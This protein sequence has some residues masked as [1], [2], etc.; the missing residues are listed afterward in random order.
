VDV[1][2]NLNVHQQILMILFTLILAFI[3]IGMVNHLTIKK[4]EQNT[5]AYIGSMF[6]N[7][8]S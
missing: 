5:D 7:I 1:L 8:K 3:V 6:I 2:K 4:L